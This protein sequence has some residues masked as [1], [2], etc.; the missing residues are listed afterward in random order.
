MD[1]VPDNRVLPDLL[2]QKPVQPI[3]PILHSLDQ[4]PPLA[5]LLLMLEDQNYLAQYLACYEFRFLVRDQPLHAFEVLV[6]FF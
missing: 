2:H 6:E 4:P 5:R 1:G 3:Q